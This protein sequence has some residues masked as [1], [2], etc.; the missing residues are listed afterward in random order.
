MHL[1]DRLSAFFSIQ[2]GEGR[3][4]TLL[5]VQYFFLGAAFVFT[6]T[7]AFALFLTEFGSRY[8]PLVYMAIAVGA[9]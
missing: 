7:T 8:L 2:A 1:T 4:V 3:L 9:S 5:T 6:Q